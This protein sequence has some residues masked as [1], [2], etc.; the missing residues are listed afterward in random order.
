MGKKG[1]RVI[2]RVKMRVNKG[3]VYCLKNSLNFIEFFKSMNFTELLVNVTEFFN[4][5]SKCM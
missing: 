2:K 1:M 4:L 3:K 5:V